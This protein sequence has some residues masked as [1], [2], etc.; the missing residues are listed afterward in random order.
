[1]ALSK[2]K[3]G[4]S[5]NPAGRPKRIFTSAELRKRLAKDMPEILEKLLTMAKDGDTS[6]IKII[7]DRTHPPL[8]GQALPITVPLGASLS[9]TGG[10][11]VNATLA[12]EIPPDIG[13]QLIAALAAQARIIEIDE[14]TKRIEVLEN[15][16]TPNS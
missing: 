5:G 15:A 7:L 9:E 8:K 1:M 16:K 10:N 6:A 4:E 2:F 11:V 13:S 3:K 14:L 12:G